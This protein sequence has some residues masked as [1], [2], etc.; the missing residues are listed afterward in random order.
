MHVRVTTIY[1]DQDRVGLAAD[2]L[3]RVDR[4]AAEAMAGNRGLMTAVD[5]QAAVLVAASYWDEPGLASQASLTQARGAATEASGG[6]LTTETFEVAAQLRC[7]DLPAGGVLRLFRP[8]APGTTPPDLAERLEHSVF[9]QLGTVEG[10]CGTEL[11]L[12]SETR[13]PVLVTMWAGPRAA[14]AGAPQVWQFLGS[15]E[16]LGIR[17]EPAEEYAVIEPAGLPR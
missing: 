11:R 2:S 1:C 12:D 14:A 13:H 5:R 8:R 9:P 4:P 3:E 17:F 16:E 10:L 6:Q 15:G 7:A